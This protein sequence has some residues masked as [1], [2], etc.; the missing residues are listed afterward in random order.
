MAEQE[1]SL[2]KS[3]HPLARF[4]PKAR[5]ELVVRGLNALSEV[6]DADFYFYKGEGHRIRDELKLAISYYEKA[7]EIDPEHEDSL[8]WTGWCY[9]SDAEDMTADDIELDNTIR[10]E[11]AVV[12]YQKL[13][14]ILEKKD[15]IW[16]GNYVV[17]LNL[18]IAQY[19]L[20]LYNEAIKSFEQ[21]LELNPEYASSYYMLGL[22]QDQLGIYH[23]ALENF[24][25]YL[26]LDALEM[27]KRP[28]W[29]PRCVEYAKSR[30]EELK[31]LLTYTYFFNIGCR[32][33]K[34]NEYKQAIEC[35]DRAIELNPKFPDVYYNLAIAQ[36]R[37]AEVTSSQPVLF[38]ESDWKKSI[39]ELYRSALKN[40]EKYL[41][42][43]DH[44]SPEN[45]QFIKYANNRIKELKEML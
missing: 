31:G 16:W 4:D 39:Q 43:E 8:F 45:Q 3:S 7:L 44:E 14:E 30:V 26:S 10:N 1:K 18:G 38:D 37:M 11:R 29:R 22:S 25:T 21:A 40:F 24:E 32:F 36:E 15:S 42:L 19:W 17:Y 23:L 35:Y 6:V 33:W 9:T 12:A 2:V 5:K 27:P 34:K 41:G 20:G 28:R 13:I